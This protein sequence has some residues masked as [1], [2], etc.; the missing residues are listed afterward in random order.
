VLITGKGRH[1]LV[2]G[3]PVVREAVSA[4]LTEQGVVFGEV[5]GN[6]GRLVVAPR[7][8]EA[9]FQR[10]ARNQLVMNWSKFIQLRYV[11]APSLLASVIVLPKIFDFYAKVSVI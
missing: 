2:A 3:R 6:A 4:V 5:A 11:L 8:L 1:S 7:E 9:L 10:H